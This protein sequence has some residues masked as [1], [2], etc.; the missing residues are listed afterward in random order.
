MKK[1]LSKTLVPI[2]S[3]CVIVVGLS[4]TVIPG[5]SIADEECSPC[6]DTCMDPPDPTCECYNSEDHPCTHPLDDN[7][8]NSSETKPLHCKPCDSSCGSE[9]ELGCKCWK[10]YPCGPE[11]GEGEYCT[12]IKNY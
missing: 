12:P 4:V 3:I 11:Y 8:P 5:S 1:L 2:A 9:H 6:G 10:N 7:C